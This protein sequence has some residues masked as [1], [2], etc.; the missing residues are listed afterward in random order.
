MRFRRPTPPSA[1][2]PSPA[3]GRR[4]APAM[5]TRRA[6]PPAP[7]G[8]SASPRRRSFPRSRAGR[9]PSTP[10]G[11]ATALPRPSRRTTVPR[12][13]APRAS[14]TRAERRR[15]PMT[16]RFPQA[17]AWMRA[18]LHHGQGHR[19]GHLHGTPRRDDLRRGHGHRRPGGRGCRGQG[20][21]RLGLGREPRDR[22]GP[23]HR[24]RAGGRELRAL[25][26]HGHR[27][28][29]ARRAGSLRHGHARRHVVRPRRQGL[30]LQLGHRGRAR[31]TCPSR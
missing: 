11:A 27:P 25:L 29:G 20:H 9:R 23:A 21:G 8:A 26:R 1:A 10:G 28:R 31:R 30:R 12:S 6:R 13:R 4:T 19:H 3:G 15:S 22:R 16:A 17:S 24:L 7:T 5:P 18:R 2:S 14:S